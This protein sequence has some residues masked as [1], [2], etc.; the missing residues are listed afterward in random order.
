MAN[1]AITRI[2]Q[3]RIIRVMDDLVS[4]ASLHPA[5]A[6][7]IVLARNWQGALIVLRYLNQHQGGL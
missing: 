1:W 7:A 2:G 6:R 4:R 5:G 3:E